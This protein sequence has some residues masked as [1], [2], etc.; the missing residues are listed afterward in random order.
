MEWGTENGVE[1]LPNGFQHGVR[2][3]KVTVDRKPEETSSAS[4]ISARREA[5]TFPR[6]KLDEHTRTTHPQCHIRDSVLSS[7]VRGAHGSP[8]Q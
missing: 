6:T 7:E 5:Q 3:T 4:R 2:E 1:E 8:P